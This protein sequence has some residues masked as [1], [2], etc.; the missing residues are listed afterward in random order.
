MTRMFCDHNRLLPCSDSC[1]VWR[2]LKCFVPTDWWKGTVN[3]GS[4]APRPPKSTWLLTGS[5]RQF[6]SSKEPGLVS[7]FFF[8]VGNVMIGLANMS[9]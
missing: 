1:S 9:I 5:Y 8:N 3:G 7:D 4:V 6:I 2:V